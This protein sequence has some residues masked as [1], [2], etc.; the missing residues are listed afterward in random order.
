MT[1]NLLTPEPLIQPA[2]PEK[3][4]E[5]PTLVP[6]PFVIPTPNINPGTEP[7]PKA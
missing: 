2:T 6:N 7:T 4:K 5:K 1:Y 3:I